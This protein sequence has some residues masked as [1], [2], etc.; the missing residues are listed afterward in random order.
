MKLVICLA[1][2]MGGAIA[3][4]KPTAMS[5]TVKLIQGL[6]ANVKKDG[7][8]E[9]ASFDTYACWCEKTME[10]KAKDIS[11]A[12]DL[13]SEMATLIMKLKGEIASHGAEIQQLQKDLAQNAEAVKE[14]TGLRNKENKDYAGERTES[15]QCIG[16]LEAGI[17]VLS[18]AG[19]KKAAFLEGNSLHEAQLL[20]V[21]A[22]LKTAL[23][24]KSSHTLSDAEAQ[25]M[26]HFVSKPMDFV[27]HKGM[28]AAQTGQNP[29]GDYA[30]QSS[31]ITGILQGMYDAMT[32]DLEKD[33]AE[34]AQ[35]QKSF[36]ELMATKAQ[37]RKTLEAT[38]QKQE[39]DSAAKSKSLSESEVT[40][41]D[42]AAQLDAD[43]KFFEDTKDSCQTKATQWSVRVRMRTEELNGMEL[44]IKILSGGAKTFESSTSTFVQLAA[45]TQHSA[46]SSNRAKAYNQLK[47]LASQYMSRSVAKIAVEVKM[48]GHFDKVI[49]MIDEMI[50]VMRKEEADDIA[51]RDRCENAENA[52]KNQAADLASSIK[53]TKAS[54]ERMGNTKKALLAEIKTLESEIADTVKSQED[55]L[56][57]RNKDSADFKQA[58]KDDHDAANLLRKAI[59]ALSSFYKRNNM[60]VPALVQKGAPAEYAQDADK[61]PEAS[62]SGDYGG[63]KSE[64]GGILAILAMLVE[65]TEKE[66]AEGRADDADAQEKCLKQNGALQAT[67]D[68]QEDTKASTET[69]LGDLEEKMNDY[70]KFKNEKKADADAEDDN[71]AAIGTD[72][73]WVKTHFKDR[74]TKRKTEIQGLV[75]AKSFLAVD[76]DALA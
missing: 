39:T 55:L 75:D 67:L 18:G 5:Q 9:Q 27:A 8:S 56:D 1:V 63:R 60:D 66:M 26:N 71:K 45:V 29:F 49:T 69:E 19:T 35:A 58:L 38:L 33:N 28:I 59:E 44:A 17:N 62:F 43:E 10:R 7:K 53:K 70:D 12:K 72:C 16:A 46:Q 47:T 11:D 21:V 64:S 40:K 34:E 48:G 15:E 23:S 30:P 37:E 3:T 50:A 57:F 51:H 68:S 41:E 32:A 36:E 76:G 14:A 42:T 24:H 52:N 22:G 54:L 25:V 2:L 6:A 31:Q 13:I 74:R 20:S 4:D 73:A 61:A 65:D